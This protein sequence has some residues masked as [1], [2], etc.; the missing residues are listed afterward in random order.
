ML[1]TVCRAH[2][3]RGH[4][5]ILNWP[6]WPLSSGPRRWRLMRP[7][8]GLCAVRGESLSEELKG[9]ASS[10]TA[11][12]PGI[13]ATN[14]LSSATTTSSKL[15]RLP[16]FLIGDV[17]KVAAEGYAAC[18]KGEVIRVP[19]VV[20]AAGMLASRATPKWVL[21]RISGALGRKSI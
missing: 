7:H 15:A 20:N 11:L 14:M 1:P 4:G 6:P 18:I 12:C 21:R 2:V 13:T 8:Q 9:T 10:I 17:D 5:R 19:G 16:G 3:A